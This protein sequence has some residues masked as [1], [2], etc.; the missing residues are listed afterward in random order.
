MSTLN[1]GLQCIG[2]MR[3]AGSELLE[4]EMTQC[5]NMKVLRRIAEKRKEFKDDLLD[6]LLNSVEPVKILLSQ[7]FQGLQLKEKTFL[8]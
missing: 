7:M 8:A 4:K 6:D 3:K 2:M 5:D 1:L